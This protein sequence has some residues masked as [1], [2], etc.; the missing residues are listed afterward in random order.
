MTP[1]FKKLLT[2][3]WLMLAT[4]IG[5]WVF[6]LHAIR[7]AVESNPSEAIQNTWRSQM[8]YGLVGIAVYLGVSMVDYRWLR[9]VAAPAYLVSVG[10]LVAALLFG[11]EINNTKGWLAIGGFKFQPSQLAIAGCVVAA[12]VTF[13]ELR[14][15]HPFF[16]NHFLNLT[17]LGVLTGIPFLLVLLQG[18]V[19]S[20]LVWIPVAAAIGIVARIPFRHLVMVALL[21]LIAIPP[22]YFFALNDARRSRIEVF[23][24]MAQ[25]KPVDIRNEGY[26]AHNISMAVGS[27]GWSGFENNA[28][29]A[30][31]AEQVLDPALR[32]SRIDERLTSVHEQG[33]IS[34]NAAHSDFIFAVIAERYGFVGSTLLI[35]AFALLL[36]QILV[37][38]FWSR[39][40]IGRILCAAVALLLFA[41][42]FQNIGMTLLIMPITGIPLPFI[43]H[44]GTFLLTLFGLLGLVQSV[45]VHR[46]IEPDDKEAA[47]RER[48]IRK[49]RSRLHPEL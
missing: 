21:A 26:S 42:V 5:L 7:I 40:A 31:E 17:L 29:K 37:T 12:S 9:W 36:L 11:Q 1:F 23:L 34:L 14:K 13:S 15:L 44:G 43:S 45:W 16:K 49:T 41:H 20:A 25:D 19:G 6:G 4:I 28:T 46:D 47:E 18:D 3:N 35:L 22:F 30:T 27:G 48:L 8:H 33:L 2:T 39:D 24:A 38:A 32:E 10:L